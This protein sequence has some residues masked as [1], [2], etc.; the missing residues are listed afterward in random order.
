M[1]YIIDYLVPWLFRFYASWKNAMENNWV[2]ASWVSYSDSITAADK[3][4]RKVSDDK[5]CCFLLFS[6]NFDIYNIKVI[7]C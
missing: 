3:V 5:T 6:I 2:L 1:R 7:G 4:I